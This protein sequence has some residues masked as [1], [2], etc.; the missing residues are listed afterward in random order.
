MKVCSGSVVVEALCCQRKGLGFETL[1]G[2][3]CLSVY[4]ILPAA[5]GPGVYAATNRNEYQK[6]KN[7]SLRSRSQR[8][9]KADNL[10]AICDLVV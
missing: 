3:L 7:V 8:V 9:R 2:E 4:L 6:Q 5:L 10:I 1:R